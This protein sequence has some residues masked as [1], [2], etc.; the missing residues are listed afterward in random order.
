MVVCRSRHDTFDGA[1]VYLK[2]AVARLF[3]NAGRGINRKRTIASIHGK[4]KKVVNGVDISDLSRWYKGWELKKL[5]KNIIKKI[6]SHKG[7]KEKN[8]EEIEKIKK[9]KIKTVET[10]KGVELGQ[11]SLISQEQQNRMV[12]AVIN[13]VANASRHSQSTL[14]FPQNGR[15]AAISAARSTHQSSSAGDD[16]STV[17]FDHLGNR[18]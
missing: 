17:T 5:P 15:T 10:D 4:D 11:G 6:M 1:V 3:P 14:S 7:H 12:A 18:L 2:T 8:K 9:A 13:G 16:T